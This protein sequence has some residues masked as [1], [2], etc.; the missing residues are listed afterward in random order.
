MG[1]FDEVVCRMESVV[2]PSFPVA[3]ASHVFGAN[4][5]GVRYVLSQ[6]LSHSQTLVPTTVLVFM[7]CPLQAGASHRLGALGQGA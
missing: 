6:P 1:L 5:Q 7:S 3:P 2:H 4:F